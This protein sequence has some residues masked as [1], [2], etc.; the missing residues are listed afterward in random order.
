MTIS[1]SIFKFISLLFQGS[2]PIYRHLIL[3]IKLLKFQNLCLRIIDNVFPDFLK[4]FIASNYMF[5]V[6]WLPDI[7]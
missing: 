3:I 2:L 7:G 4:S 1:R 6:T 5:I